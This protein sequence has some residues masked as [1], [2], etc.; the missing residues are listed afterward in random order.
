MGAEPRLDKAK[1]LELLRAG[2]EHEGL[3]Y[4][5]QLDLSDNGALL[6]LVKDIA[7]FSAAGGYIVVGCDDSG[8]P[9]PLLSEAQR[10]LFDESRLRA[11]V[12]RYLPEPLA[13]RTACH[14]HDGA[15]F[16]LVYIGPHPDGFVIVHADGQTQNGPSSA[17]AKSSSA[18]ARPASAGSRMTSR[19]S[20]RS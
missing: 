9:T 1:L 10:V 19:R 5:R 4:K 3:D 13:L 15:R 17:A 20:S 6:E 16:V 2:H 8:Q 7:A 11:K 12:K 14:E 18:T